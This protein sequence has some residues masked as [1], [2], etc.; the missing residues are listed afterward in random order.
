M[1]SRFRNCFL[2][3]QEGG[4]VGDKFMEQVE[5]IATQVPYMVAPG[6]HEWLQ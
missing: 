5:P 1:A 2:P 6:N 3:L 4:K